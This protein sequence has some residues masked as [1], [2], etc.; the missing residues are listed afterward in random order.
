MTRTETTLD[1]SQK[2]EKVCTS[3]QITTSGLQDV[4]CLQ[5]IEHLQVGLLPENSEQ[6]SC[7]HEQSP[8]LQE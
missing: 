2:T 1:H 6:G 4:H 7:S 5:R 3:V 8:A